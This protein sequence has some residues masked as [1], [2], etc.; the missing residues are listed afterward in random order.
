MNDLFA[1]DRS[2]RKQAERPMSTS[3]R[4]QMFASAGNWALV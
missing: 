1:K 4:L 2:S 3:C